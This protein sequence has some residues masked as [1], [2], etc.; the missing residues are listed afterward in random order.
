MSLE[1][2]GEP[3]EGQHE[4]GRGGAGRHGATLGGE[5]AASVGEAL[6]GSCEVVLLNDFVVVGHA[7]GSIAAEQLHALHEAPLGPQSR[8]PI[9]CLG[10]GTGLGNV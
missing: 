2:R 9:A 3:R 8:S 1:E 10:P 6:G 5:S 7:L 4:H